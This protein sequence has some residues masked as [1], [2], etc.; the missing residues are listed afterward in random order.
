[1]IITYSIGARRTVLRIIIYCRTRGA[2]LTTATMTN[3]HFRIW[4][5][6]TIPSIF[7]FRCVV[8]ECWKSATGLRCVRCA[9]IVQRLQVYLCAR[10]YTVHAFR[11]DVEFIVQQLLSQYC[12]TSRASGRFMYV[13]D[14]VLYGAGSTAAA[15]SVSKRDAKYLHYLGCQKSVTALYTWWLRLMTISWYNCTAHC[16]VYVRMRRVRELRRVYL[17]GR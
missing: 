7:H 3:V 5:T 2:P 13:F 14:A 15:G 16:G 17:C 4:P 1:M 9:N 6:P 8:G 10:A 12:R 11:V